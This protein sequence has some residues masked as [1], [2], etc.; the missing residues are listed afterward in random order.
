MAKN[1][2]T[3]EWYRRKGDKAFVSTNDSRQIVRGL[4][5]NASIKQ[6]RNKANKGKPEI[7]PVG[8]NFYGDD[9]KAKIR[10]VKSLRISRGIIARRKLRFKL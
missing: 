2:L 7:E 10:K 5:K 6:I 3:G 9:R 4:P 1:K 8:A